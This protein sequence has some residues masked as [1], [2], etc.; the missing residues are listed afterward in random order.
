L[1]F[2]NS[3]LFCRPHFVH[4]YNISAYSLFAAASVGLSTDDIIAG[5]NR[6]SKNY[7]PDELKEYIKTNTERCGKVKILLDG[8]RYY[9]ESQSTAVLDELLRDGQISSAR[10]DHLDNRSDHRRD[11]R[12]RYLKSTIV[13]GDVIELPGSSSG[14]VDQNAA[15]GLIDE[16]SAPAKPA[17]VDVYSFE[18]EQKKVEVVRKQCNQMKYP[19]LEEYDFRKDKNAEELPISLKPSAHIRSYQEKSLSKMFGNGRA[20]SGI[21]VLPCGAGKTLVGI[22]ATCTVRRNTLVF[23]NT[24]VSVNQWKQQYLRFANI[25]DTQVCQFTSTVKDDLP[26]NKAVLLITTYNMLAF[27]GNRSAKAQEILDQIQQKEWGLIILDEVHVAPARTFRQ[28]LGMTKSRCKLGLTATLLRE[29]DLIE[30]LFFLIGPKLYEANWLSLQKAGFLATVQC[31]E[32]RCPMT[33]EFYKEYLSGDTKKQQLLYV[34]NPNKFRACQYLI[35]WHEKRGD[36]I[37]VFSD[38][39]FALER[40]AKDLKKPYL[41]G[42]TSER[43]RLDLLAHLQVDDNFNTLFISKV[44][45]TSIDLPDVNV[46]IQI[47]S[48]FSSRRQEAQR[49]G[50]I[51]RP[52]P[53]SSSRFNA[54]FYTLISEDTKEVRYATKRQSFLVDQ[55]YS[56]QAITYDNLVDE[57]EADNLMYGSLMDQLRLLS[58]VLASSD[59]AGNIED[60]ADQDEQ[61]SLRQRMKGRNPR[62]RQGSLASITGGKGM[63]YEETASSKKR[64]SGPSKFQALV[65]NETKRIK[66]M[67]DNLRGEA[68]ELLEEREASRIEREIRRGEQQQQQQQGRK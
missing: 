44:G 19:T 38:I 28:C 21:I 67:T 1:H 65:Q 2:L 3:D 54:F 20:R 33:K 51:L 18:I 31:V 59:D 49:L 57:I 60:I 58:N 41:H 8:G 39:I 13:E 66:K 37:L 22:T 27:A 6:F 15:M 48:H 62:R 32:V 23:C 45:D 52:K 24:G 17:I 61:E 47:S 43:E 11:K 50:R 5:L 10:I 30:D 35:D 16:E 4:E 25:P 63:L 40:Y 12:T 56:F 68:E 46:I 26:K 34:M 36:K 53:S 64:Q 9:V 55:G 14:I 42:S 29:D 7:L